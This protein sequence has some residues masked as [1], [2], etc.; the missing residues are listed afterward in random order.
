MNNKKIVDSLGLQYPICWE[1]DTAMAR[2]KKEINPRTKKRLTGYAEDCIVHLNTSI[3]KLYTLI[4]TAYHEEEH[5]NIEKRRQ[6]YPWFE[7]KK[8]GGEIWYE[9]AMCNLYA[10][11]KT[12]DYWGKSFK[13]V[14]K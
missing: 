9:E 13:K 11:C 4:F 5:C 10:L 1:D 6:E 7:H 2:V 14:K 12:I 8:F 3:T